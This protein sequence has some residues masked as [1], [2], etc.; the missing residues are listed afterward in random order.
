MSSSSLEVPRRQQPAKRSKIWRIAAVV[1]ALALIAGW[2]AWFVLT[3]DDLPVTSDTVTERGVVDK[4]LYVG[5]FA[6]GDGFDR[7]IRISEVAADV[8]SEGDVEVTPQICR[9]GTISVT[10]DPSGSCAELVDTDD[11]EFRPGDSIIVAVTATEPTTVSIGRL[12]VSFREGLHWGT[13][14]AGLASAT[15]TFADQE[16]APPVQDEAGTETDSP[17]ERPGEDDGAGTNGDKKKDKKD[18]KDEKKDETKDKRKD[19]RKDE[20]KGNGANA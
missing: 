4:T 13:K 12:D 5:M 16:P 19:E 8:E 2:V 15:L 1:G 7:S 18:K 14:E 3:P 11:A 9:E 20:K 6:V 17:T 10:T